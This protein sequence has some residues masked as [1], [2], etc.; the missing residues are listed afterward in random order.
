MKILITG[1]TGFIGKNLLEH[2]S[3]NDCYPFTRGENLYVTLR[4]FRPDMVINS[5]AEIYEPHKMWE[6]NVEFTKICLDWLVQNPTKKMIQLGSSIEYGMLDRAATERDPI[7]PVDMYST[8]K[9]MA[10]LM[11]QG[12]A[13]QF[14]L[15]VTVVR[16]YSIFGKYE[17]PHRLFPR[18]WR[19]FTMDVPM[20]LYAG[21]HDF[22]YI[23]DFIH[24][25]D[26]LVNLQQPTN[27]DIVH[28]ASGI[29]TSN[30]EVL[31]IFE[32]ITGKTSPVEYKP[33]LAKKFES[34]VW[35]GDTTY[36][37]EQY[38]FSCNYTLEQ[39]IEHFLK[40]ADYR[41]I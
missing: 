16:P 35:K 32:K 27:G 29:Q 1:S 7:L 3:E 17:R 18:L 14:G 20:T 33:V 34:T 30:K 9:G 8:T 21:E 15:D 22:V 2:F 31:E 19:A 40:T 5:A 11:C 6:P 10:T 36:A 41:K 4:K 25:I 37:R 26:L 38:G 24:G 12:Y 13:R 23:D 28:F 39:G